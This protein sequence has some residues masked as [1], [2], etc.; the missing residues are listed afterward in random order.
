MFCGAAIQYG[1]NDGG[2]SLYPWFY[3]WDATSQAVKEGYKSSNGLLIG[4]IDIA[5]IAAGAIGLN[6]LLLSSLIAFRFIKTKCGVLAY[7]SPRTRTMYRTAIAA[8]LESGLVYSAFV[9]M[10]FF[11]EVNQLWADLP[12]DDT[13]LLR[14]TVV[15]VG[16]RAWPSLAILLKFSAPRKQGIMSN[17]I[18]VR[19]A[20]DVVLHSE[21]SGTTLPLYGTTANSQMWISAQLQTRTV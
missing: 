17:I 12:D 7:L 11:V 5:A 2:L 21:N 16:L 9:S 20:L 15:N 1:G 4:S 10:I 13:L 14:H 3:I 18:I 8:T 6:N 19:V